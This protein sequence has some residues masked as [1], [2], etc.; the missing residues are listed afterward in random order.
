MIFSVL[1][2]ANLDEN[3]ENDEDN[4]PDHPDEDENTF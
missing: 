3:G 4:L 2:I 1:I